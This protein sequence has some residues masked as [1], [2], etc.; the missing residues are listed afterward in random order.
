MK[1]LNNVLVAFGA[2]M[3]LNGCGLQTGDE[4]DTV[5]VPDG[6]DGTV[7][8]ETLP[9]PFRSPAACGGPPRLAAYCEYFPKGD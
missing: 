9:A 5:V 4:T 6:D 8:A 7:A 2:M 3:V 1:N